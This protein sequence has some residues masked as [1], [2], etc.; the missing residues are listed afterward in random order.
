LGVDLRG[1]RIQYA[2]GISADGS[3][4]VGTAIGPNGN[5]EAYLAVVPADY[6]P[7]PASAYLVLMAA[8]GWRLMRGRRARSWRTEYGSG[9]R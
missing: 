2:Q 7:E 3:V 6:V 5:P 4:I 1:Y 9:C 8:A